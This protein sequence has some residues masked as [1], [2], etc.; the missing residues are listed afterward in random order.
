MNNESIWCITAFVAGQAHW[1]RWWLIFFTRHCHRCFDQLIEHF[2]S[3]LRSVLL[4]ALP[5]IV[6]LIGA[7]ANHLHNYD[8]YI[9]VDIY[10]S[11]ILLLFLFV[12]AISLSLSPVWLVAVGTIRIWLNLNCKKKKQKNLNYVCCMLTL[13]DY[14]KDKFIAHMALWMPHVKKCEQSRY[15]YLS[16]SVEI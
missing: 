5:A 1:R 15:A 4:G 16:A 6:C 12:M 2:L 14:D 13:Y 9:H 10:S 7:R 3:L 8:T 11:P